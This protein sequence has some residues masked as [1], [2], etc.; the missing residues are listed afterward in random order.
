M[1][2]Y[3]RRH[4]QQLARP[5]LPRRRAGRRSASGGVQRPTRR[6]IES[7]HRDL[8]GKRPKVVRQDRQDSRILG[9][10]GPSSRAAADH[11]GVMQIV[12]VTARQLGFARHA[13]RHSVC[14]GRDRASREARG[15][16]GD[17]YVV[18]TAGS[19]DVIVEVVCEDDHDLLE[20]LNTQ[21]RAL[22]GVTATE[23]LVYLK[24][25]KQQYNWGTPCV[26]EL[27]VKADRHLWGHFARH[28]P[29]ITAPIIVRGEGVR[30]GTT[31]PCYLDGLSGL[32]VVQV[33]HGRA[34]LA[35]A[36]ARQARSLRS[37]RCGPMRRHRR[38]NW[39][40]GSRTTRPAT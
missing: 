4:E 40:N 19:F 21:I 32:F 31:R 26:T 9:G 16:S 5:T 29:G 17:C 24:L 27:S 34:E 13:C 33:G 11:A 12:A 14:R 6:P 25:V 3:S 36:A 18:H 8:A 20:P 23:S 22:R 30:S 1:N 39:P 28:G 15:D 35:E 37:S 38:S 2:Q 10:C 7:D